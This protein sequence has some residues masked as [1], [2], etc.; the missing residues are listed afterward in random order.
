MTSL[1]KEFQDTFHGDKEVVSNIIKGLEK[2]SHLKLKKSANT[3]YA[4]Y[5]LAA[6]HLIRL[7]LQIQTKA[8]GNL[9]GIQREVSGTLCLESLTSVRLPI[10]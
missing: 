8:A 10:M 4:A 2:L 9:L 1:L 3:S 5:K 6:S 7:V